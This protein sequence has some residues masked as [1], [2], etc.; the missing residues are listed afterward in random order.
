MSGVRNYPQASVTPQLP[1]LAANC[2]DVLARV[3]LS[4]ITY[5]SSSARSLVLMVAGRYSK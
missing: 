4:S 3:L 1:R 5:Y 2:S